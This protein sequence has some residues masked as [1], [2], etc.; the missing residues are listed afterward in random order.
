MGCFC[1]KLCKLWGSAAV[2]A[3][4][5][6]CFGSEQELSQLP[7]LTTLCLRGR[8]HSLAAFGGKLNPAVHSGPCA[9]PVPGTRPSLVQ[10]RDRG[11]ARHP[12]QS[13][14]TQGLCRSLGTHVYGCARAAGTPPHP[15]AGHG[16]KVTSE[17]PKRSCLLLECR[18]RRGRA[19]GSTAPLRAAREPAA[20]LRRAL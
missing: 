13:S 7:P 15:T 20:G 11:A 4:L 14:V 9:C 18:R 17:V 3:L 2:G 16:L 1:G 8:V 10:T 19:G 12:L 6:Y 5:H